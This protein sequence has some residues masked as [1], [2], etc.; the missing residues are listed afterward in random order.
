MQWQRC[1]LM[2]VLADVRAL[3]L[4]AKSSDLCSFG[5]ALSLSWCSRC[6]RAQEP[7]SSST[8]PRLATVCMLRAPFQTQSQR[9]RRPLG[10]PAWQRSNSYIRRA[11]S[12]G[13]TDCIPIIP[14]QPCVDYHLLVALFCSPFQRT[15]LPQTRVSQHGLLNLQLTGTLFV[16]VT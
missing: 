12:I 1:P 13:R 4:A 5:P 10:T 2:Y 11:C 6:R 9:L 14:L 15:S 8:C 3:L 7:T 16:A